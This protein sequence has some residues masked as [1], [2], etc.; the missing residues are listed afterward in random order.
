MSF[1]KKT[2]KQ[3]SLGGL[4][5][6]ARLS[7]KIDLRTVSQ[8]IKI[9]QKYLKCIEE[10]DFYKLPGLT[11]TR[12]FL[13][14]Y[15]EFLGLDSEKI[16]KQWREEYC[17]SQDVIREQK[18]REAKKIKEEN[19]LAKKINLKPVLF[20]FLLL[21]FLAYLGSSVKNVLIS[22]QIE[23]IH[24]PKEFVTDNSSLLIVGKTNPRAEVFV[25]YQIV[26][27]QEQGLFEQEINLLPGL[28]VIRV[29]AKKKYSQE[30]EVILRVV[31]EKE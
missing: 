7:C 17:P 18:I 1:T 5:R 27:N 25:N 16:I 19:K 29:S 20:V 26:K 2:I 23:I 6:Q 14:K 30:K 4:L 3:D 24:P 8:E 22:P 21:L 13:E 15:A 28:N 10:D 11:Y 9:D 12:G 31:L